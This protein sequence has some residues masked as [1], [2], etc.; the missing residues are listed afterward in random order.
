[1]RIDQVYT[2]SQLDEA[3]IT[4]DPIYKAFRRIG[5]R[6]ISEQEAALPSSP[7]C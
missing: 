6:I 5:R 1:M 7:S 4:E 2:S 3:W